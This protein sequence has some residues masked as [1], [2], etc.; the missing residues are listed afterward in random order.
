MNGIAPQDVCIIA[1]DSLFYREFD[2]SQAISCYSETRSVLWDFY[3]YLQLK[4]VKYAPFN[5]FLCLF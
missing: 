1:G 2:L 4:D 3:D 5:P